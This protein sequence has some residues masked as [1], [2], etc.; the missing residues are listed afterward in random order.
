MLDTRPILLV[1]GILLS[2]L[3]VTML[4]PAA[5]DFI[6]GS[7]DWQVFFTSGFVT[8]FIGLALFFA[9][10]GFSGDLSI[11]QTFL[12]TTSSWFVIPAFAAIPFSL[13]ALDLGYTDAYFESVSAMTTTGSTVMSGLDTAPPGILLWRSLLQALGGIGVIVLAM[14]VLPMLRIGGMQLFRSESSDKTDKVLPRATQIAGMIGLVYLTL[15]LI[16]SIC[17]WFAGMDG[18]DAICHA[19]TTIST[20]GFST[21]DAS[22]GYFDDPLIEYIVTLFML[23]GGIPMVL[24]YQAIRGHPEKLYNNSQVIW[25]LAIVFAVISILVVWLMIVDDYS[26][27]QAWRYSSFSVISIITTTVYA[28]IDYSIWGS[29]AVTLFFMLI[30]VGGCTGSTAGGIKIFRFQV[31]YATANAQVSQLTHPHGIFVPRYDKKPIDSKASSSVLRFF[32]LF[33]FCFMII[34]ILLSAFGLDFLTSMSAAAQA[35][36]NVGPGLGDIVGP[37]GNFKPLP[38][39]AKWLLSFAMVLGRLELFTV[40]VLFSPHFWKE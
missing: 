29:M 11:R 28:S 17:F 31:L 8:G 9:N 37:S 3:A 2:I 35:L 38:D 27:S 15:I 20:G 33:A 18:F 13:S 30:V 19:M 32:I 6:L 25:Y 26:L 5:L 39:G 1:N 23:A 34:A 21:H 22:I 12:F 10:R 4:I 7:E 14:A 24:Y 36:A 16:C 40:L